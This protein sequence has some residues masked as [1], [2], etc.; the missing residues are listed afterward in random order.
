MTSTVER[1][2][3]TIHEQLYIGGEWVDSTG[4]GRTE[5]VNPAAEG[6][7]GYV[8]QG[9]VADATAAIKAARQAFD[10]EPWPRMCPVECAAVLRRMAEAMQRGYD[11]LITLNV[12]KA[13][14]TL[15]LANFPR[16]A[17]PIENLLDMADRVL[18]RFDFETVMA[19]Y[20]NA[21]IGHLGWVDVLA[22]SWALFAVCR[23]GAVCAVRLVA[24]DPGGDLCS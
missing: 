8:P 3:K 19:P 7:L 23:S 4:D 15:A 21:F 12:A 6:V 2:L 9:A 14:S 5:V 11:S 22:Y 1:A 17:T 10:E 13:G 24:G 20:T 18:P 16:V